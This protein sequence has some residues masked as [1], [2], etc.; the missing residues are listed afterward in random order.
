MPRVLC[1]KCARPESA[2]ICQFFIATPNTTPVVILRHPKES[3][4]AKNTTPLLEHSLSQCMVIEGEEFSD[5]DILNQLLTDD[6]KHCLLLYPSDQAI[7][8]AVY[9]KQPQDSQL[10]QSC[11]ETSTASKQTVLI[12][13]DATWKKAYRMYM[14]SKNLQAIAHVALPE[15]IQGEYAIRK[16]Q[17]P[18]A[19]STFEAAVHALTIIEGCE[20]RYKKLRESFI[21][22]NQ[23]Q[24]SYRR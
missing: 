3:L 18:N 23:H 21:R 6:K 12:L 2:C 4:H 10:P 9:A 7:E 11:K 1:D 16:T 20:S 17:K 14:L 24:L 15:N 22:F 19:L 13:L 5:N 8:L